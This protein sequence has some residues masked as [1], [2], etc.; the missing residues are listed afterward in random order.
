MNDGENRRRYRRV[1]VNLPF[2]IAK[3]YTSV[4]S[5]GHTVD[6]SQGGTRAILTQHFS[7]FSQVYLK[8]SSQDGSVTLDV[9]G[10]VLWI[11]SHPVGKELQYLSGLQFMNLHTEESKK[12][13]QQLMVKGK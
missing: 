4:Y 5:D 10:R 8:L 9:E 3:S 11:K 12:I 7:P 1:K 13:I 2:K 6:L